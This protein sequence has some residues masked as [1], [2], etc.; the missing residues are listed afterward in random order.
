VAR[1]SRAEW[2]K[3]VE[4]WGDSGLSAKEYASQTGLKASTLSYWKWRLGSEQRASSAD[5]TDQKCARPGA[6]KRRASPAVSAPRFVEVTPV[7]APS[8]EPLTLVLPGAITVRVPVGF[9][10]DTLG[11]VLRVVRVSS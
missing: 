8:A 7:D 9:D 4:R 1:T 10:E 11:R 5:T 3:R 6:S 2:Q